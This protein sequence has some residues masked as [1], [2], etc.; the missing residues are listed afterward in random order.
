M[1]KKDYYILPDGKIVFTKE[2]H[3][4]RGKCCGNRCLNC[5]Y[6]YINVEEPKKS[7]LLKKRQ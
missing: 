7:E 1:E 6:D 2:F 4:K 5:P 3:L